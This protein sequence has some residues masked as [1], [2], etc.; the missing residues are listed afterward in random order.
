MIKRIHT[1]FKDYLS[2]NEKLSNIS[3]YKQEYINYYGSLS[4]KYGNFDNIWKKL[5]KDFKEGGLLNIPNKVK[6]SRLVTLNNKFNPENNIHW[7]RSSDEYL[8]YDKD[9]L[10][11]TDIKI[12]EN[13]K[14]IRI[15]IDK[16]LID[17]ENTIIQNLQF[18]IEKEISLKRNINIKDYTIKGY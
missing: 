18:P 6:L 1:T 9:W 15:E 13:T 17:L 12:N 3:K 2:L 5:N 14:I 7:V 8:F 16:D 11:L 4:D 10:F